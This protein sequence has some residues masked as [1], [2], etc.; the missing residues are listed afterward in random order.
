MYSVNNN[1][2]Y[3]TITAHY[4][5]NEWNLM[6]HLLQIRAVETSHTASNL[7]KL[8]F[9]AIGEWELTDKEAAI[10]M[11]NVAN[12]VRAVE[13]MDLLH[14]SCFAHILNLA[15]QAALKVPAV[16]CL[17]GIVGHTA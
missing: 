13:M 15:S 12:I 8:L 17:L 10:A 3:L 14:V 7:S 6:T 11:D 16:T 2:S 1:G 4:I 9:E 5:D